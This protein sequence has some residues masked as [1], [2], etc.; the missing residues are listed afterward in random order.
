MANQ[1]NLQVTS[2]N[3]QGEGSNDSVTSPTEIVEVLDESMG[4]PTILAPNASSGNDQAV[5]LSQTSRALVPQGRHS[6]QSVISTPVPFSPEKAKLRQEA[7]E[8]QGTLQQ[9]A[10]YVDNVPQGRNY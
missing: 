9:A 1:P 10:H 2:P 6:N 7:N 3:L 4:Q 5:A 8:L